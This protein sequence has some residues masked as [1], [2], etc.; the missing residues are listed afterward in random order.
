MEVDQIFVSTG[1]DQV[2]FVGVIFNTPLV[3][4]R[5]RILQ[6]KNTQFSPNPNEK[7][8][9]SALGSHLMEYGNTKT[10][11]FC[12]KYRVGQ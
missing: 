12:I 2:N 9:R 7:I 6:H 8:L 1:A 5:Q 4:A 11:L 10:K 3:E